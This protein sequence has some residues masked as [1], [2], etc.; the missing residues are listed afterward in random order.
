M[1][2]AMLGLDWWAGF[3]T[4]L[5]FAFC[6]LV[7]LAMGAQNQMN[8]LGRKDWRMFDYDDDDDDEEEE[9]DT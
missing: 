7:I 6:L 8:Q 5:L 4:G 3:V 9:E 2:I 1:M